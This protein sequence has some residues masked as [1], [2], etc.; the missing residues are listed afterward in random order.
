MIDSGEMPT[1]RE[2]SIIDVDASQV[3]V[4]AV[5]KALLRSIA[6]RPQSVRK[7]IGA[8]MKLYSFLVSQALDAHPFA[9]VLVLLI[10]ML[11]PVLVIYLVADSAY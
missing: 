2:I 5:R 8:H 9:R 6:S 3:A 7:T 10:V 11:L 4:D 1:L